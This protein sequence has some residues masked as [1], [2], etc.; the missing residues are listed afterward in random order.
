MGIELR[1]AGKVTEEP[2]EQLRLVGQALEWYRDTAHRSLDV[3]CRDWSHC[4][5]YDRTHRLQRCYTEEA[6]YRLLTGDELPS[7]PGV[8]CLDA[9]G[10]AKIARRSATGSVKIRR[11]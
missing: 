2:K 11:P 3:P 5:R 7:Q 9:A 4:R 10:M 8:E 6:F 1:N